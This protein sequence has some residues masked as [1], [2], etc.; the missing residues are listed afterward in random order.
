MQL[1]RSELQRAA[2]RF[3]E[4]QRAAVGLLEMPHPGNSARAQMS[5]IRGVRVQHVGLW[6][7]C[8]R[9]QVC[10]IHNPL[11]VGPYRMCVSGCVGGG[12]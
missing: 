9:V 6:T 8:G 7:L 4:M 2:V 5:V 12:V 1:R 11:A 10:C 3:I